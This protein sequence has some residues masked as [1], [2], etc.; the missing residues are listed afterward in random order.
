MPER[1]LDFDTV[2]NRRGTNSLKYDFALQRGRPA[3]VLP[4]WVADMDFRTSSYIEDA[5]VQRSHDAI[6]GYSEVGDDYFNAVNSWM[7]SHFGWNTDPSWLIKTPGVVFAL[8]MAVKAYTEPGDAVLIQQPV[9]YPF[10]EVIE[11]NGRR[12]VSNDLILGDDNRYHIDFDDFEKQIKE[13]DIKLFM[14][15]NP[16]NPTGRVFTEQELERLGDISIYYGVI[17]VS[18]EIH[19]D[20][21]FSGKHTVF[22]SIKKEFALNSITCTAASKTFNLASM[23]ISD[24]FIPDR[25]LRGIFAHEVAA[26]GISQLSI[27]GEVATQ[28]AYEHGQEWYEALKKYLKSNIDYVKTYVGKNLPGV[29]VIDAEGTYLLWLDFRGLG[30]STDELERKIV[31]DAR[32]WFDSGSVFGKTGEGFERINIAAPRTLITECMNRL[33]N[34]LL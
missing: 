29:K 5:L 15:C 1:N 21:V 25:M 7:V 31:Y 33:K 18:D 32:L 8:A 23:M 3:D 11:D 14:L 9:Y 20:F 10:S 13:N 34:A 27:L 2:I 26:A 16:Q 24:I 6:F 30:L 12:V 28:T 4:Y 17:V 22:A 19:E